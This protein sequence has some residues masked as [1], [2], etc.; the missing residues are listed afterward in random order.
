MIVRRGVEMPFRTIVRPVRYDDFDRWLPLWDGYNSF[1]GRTQ[2]TALP[3][4]ITLKTWERFLDAAEPM[5]ALVAERDGELVGLVHY[6]FHPN[7]ISFGPD[8]YLRDLFLM[9]KARG[10][11][12]GKQLIEAVEKQ[13]TR[14]NAERLYWLTHESNETA[15]KLYD[16]VAMNSGFLMYRK[17]L[18]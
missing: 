17:S 15:R 18:G 11:G 8:C 3:T 7:T 4:E 9:E 5:H 13:A 14:A 16:K 2:S 12:I 10:S 6:L 1:Y